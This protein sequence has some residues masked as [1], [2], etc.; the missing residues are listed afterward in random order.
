MLRCHR[1]GLPES[2]GGGGRF[3]HTVVAKTALGPPAAS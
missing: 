2:Q 1:A 3:F